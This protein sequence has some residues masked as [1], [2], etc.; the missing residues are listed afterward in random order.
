[1][2]AAPGNFDATA[3]L[4]ALVSVLGPLCVP[5]EA[6]AQ[7]GAPAGCT[8]APA[9][10]LTV[11]VRDKG[12]KG[13]G[14]TDDAAAIQRAIDE[15]GGK[16]GTVF[17]P[18][19]TYMVDG[20]GPNRI[21]LKNR[22]TFKL[23]PGA[24]LRTIPNGETHSAV[25]TIA[26]VSN[27]TVT[28]GTLEGD[29]DR[30]Q[31]TTGEWGHGIRVELG[32]Q[33]IS[34]SEITIKDMWG[35]GVF[36]DT[37]TDVALCRVVADRNRRQGLSVIAAERVLVTHSI[38]KNTRGT[39]PSAGIDLEPDR[40]NQKYRTCVSCTRSFSTMRGPVF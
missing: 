4:L 34:I 12:A 1:M 10:R 8:N 15:V 26:G 9:S 7:S 33:Q 18:D 16:G 28:G 14:R 22:M 20:I 21:T 29:R 40:A 2:N 38:F 5:F 31:G 25:L 3:A 11:N 37:A 24:T 39:R 13:D 17:V 6:F 36:I 19:G 32:A 30:H 23:S 35:D 27:V